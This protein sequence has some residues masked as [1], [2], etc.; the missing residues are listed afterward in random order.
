MD[1]TPA[2]ATAAAAATAAVDFGI[3]NEWP[4]AAE[5]AAA[6]TASSA[7]GGRGSSG[8]I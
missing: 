2:T 6:T 3:C 1:A 7:V 8:S 4:V 5:D